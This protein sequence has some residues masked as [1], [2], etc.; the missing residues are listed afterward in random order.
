MDKMNL[1]A[2]GDCNTGGADALPKGDSLPDQLA[3]MLESS[4]VR[5]NVVNLGHTM[6]TSREGVLKVKAEVQE[7]DIVLLNYGLADAWITA[8]PAMSLKP[9]TR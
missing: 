1:Y 2:V 9:L 4:G 7:P 8:I 5:V 3:A 6:T